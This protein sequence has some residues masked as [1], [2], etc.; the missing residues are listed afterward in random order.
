MKL[1]KSKKGLTLIEVIISLAILGIIITPI[2]TMTINTVKINKVSEDK[3]EALAIAQEYM[4]YI[5]SPLHSVK[6]G[7]DLPSK[8]GEF[9]V[10]KV[11]KGVDEFENGDS[12]IVGDL[13]PDLDIEIN[14]NNIVGNL[15][16]KGNK[17]INE[18]TL[19]IEC[20]GNGGNN[21]DKHGRIQFSTPGKNN[22]GHYHELKFANGRDLVLKI[23]LEKANLPFKLNLGNKYSGNFIVYITPSDF[24]VESNVNII[25]N[26]N[27]NKYGK[28]IINPVSG[29]QKTY[30]LYKVIIKVWKNGE[31]DTEVPLQTL[32]SYKAITN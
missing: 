7:R 12:D 21:N 6:E 16:G 23:H 22:I 3:Q 18:N 30:D 8:K 2:Y 29:K 17:N 1:R 5:K 26:N 4:E 20:I 25:D 28:V 10:E 32:E 11:I 27:N 24:D 14:G 31:E 19:A 13:K 9:I 15:N